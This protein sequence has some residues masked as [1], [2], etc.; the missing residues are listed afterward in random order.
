M[1]LSDSRIFSVHGPPGCWLWMAVVE[2]SVK[3]YAE[4]TTII[5]ICFSKSLAQTYLTVGLKVLLGYRLECP[6]L[7]SP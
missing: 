4:F 7:Y 6:N 5:V 3:F 2:S 1:C